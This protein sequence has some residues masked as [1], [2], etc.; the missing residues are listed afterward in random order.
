MNLFVKYSTAWDLVTSEITKVNGLKWGT[1][2]RLWDPWGFR[3]F[4]VIGSWNKCVGL[5]PYGFL[6]MNIIIKMQSHK[7]MCS[8]VISIFESDYH[9][10]TMLSMLTNQ[11]T[12]LKCDFL[13]IPNK[14]P[15]VRLFLIHKQSQSFYF[16]IIQYM[17][18]KYKGNI[19]YG[20]KY[21]F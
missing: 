1:W 18:K 16:S 15:L 20:A 19:K 21:S 8:Y 3:A 17:L 14:N 5:K 6:K 12:F 9:L 2:L 13:T 4:P 11:M 7:L 10:P